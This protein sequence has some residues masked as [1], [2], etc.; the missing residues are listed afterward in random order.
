MPLILGQ[1]NATRNKNV[2]KEISAGKPVAQAVAIGYSEQ[3]K[4]KKEKR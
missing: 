4:A 1:S 2:A 3:S